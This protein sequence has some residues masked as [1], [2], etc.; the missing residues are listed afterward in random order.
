MTLYIHSCRYATTKA[1]AHVLLVIQAQ[2]VRIQ[3]C[4]NS[5]YIITHSFIKSI[6]V[7]IRVC[8]YDATD[9]SDGPLCGDGIRQGEEECDCGGVP[10]VLFYIYSAHT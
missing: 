2:H 9:G 4:V 5:V 8:L 10:Q 3:V 7:H 6:Y 1:S